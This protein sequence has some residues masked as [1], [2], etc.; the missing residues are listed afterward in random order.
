[1][2][3]DTFNDIGEGNNSIG[4]YT[5]GASP[6]LPADSLPPETIDLQS[7]HVFGVHLDY[8]GVTLTVTITDMSVPAPRPTFTKSYTVDIP[9]EVGGST[10]YVGF[11]ASTGGSTSKQEV[12][13]WTY[14][15]GP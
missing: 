4:L 7:G 6:A 15:P 9:A 5:G 10:A 13:T 1:M 11:T 14:T 3:F 8:S 12:L 2:K